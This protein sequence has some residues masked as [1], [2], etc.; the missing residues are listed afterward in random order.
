M[1]DK[2]II[3]IINDLFKDYKI[4]IDVEQKKIIYYKSNDWCLGIFYL[5]TNEF[6]S[7]YYWLYYNLIKHFNNQDEMKD[8]IKP[9]LEKIINR[10][11]FIKN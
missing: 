5:E 9:I 7:G 2:E 3:R 4:K 11:F 8:Y 6:D 10:K 1:K